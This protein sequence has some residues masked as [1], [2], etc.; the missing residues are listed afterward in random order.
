MWPGY[1]GASVHGPGR[2]RAERP[3]PGD[4][5]FRQVSVLYER[6]RPIRGLLVRTPESSSIE[7]LPLLHTMSVR[8]PGVRRA[9]FLEGG[10]TRIPG[11]G[12]QPAV[13][14]LPVRGDGGPSGSGP[15]RADLWIDA[16]PALDTQSVGLW[17]F[18]ALRLH[19]RVL[20]HQARGCRTGRSSRSTLRTAPTRSTGPATTALMWTKRRPI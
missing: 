10:A 18:S 7:G 6:V 2:S 9:T 14:L 17:P 11:A 15:S 19:L 12:L 4:A 20:G 13:S 5:A 8:R 3:P 1:G 16:E